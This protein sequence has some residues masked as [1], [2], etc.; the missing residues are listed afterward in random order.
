MSDASVD[1]SG[2]GSVYGLMAEFDSPQ[3]LLTA[4]E[5]T[6]GAGYKQID[7]FSPFPVEGLADAIGFHKNRVS[8]VVLIGGIIGGLSGYLLQYYVSVISYPVNIGGRPLH[9]W[10]SFIIVTFELTILFGGLSAA[11]GMIAL[12]GLPMPYHPVF[13]VPEFAKASD[14]KFFLVVFASDPKYDA[15]RTREFLKGLAPRAISEVPS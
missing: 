1:F 10:P 11:I 9:S 7:A 15:A 8:L 12:N 4:A 3:E 6:H 14:D 13:N 5:K 2:Q